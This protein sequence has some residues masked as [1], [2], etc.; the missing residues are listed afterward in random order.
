MVVTEAKTA[1]FARLYEELGNKGGEKKLRQFAKV[2]ENDAIV[3]RFTIKHTPQQNGVAERMN[4]TLLEKVRCKL[5]NAGL[6]KEFWAEAVTYACHLINHLLSAAVDG[7]TPFEKWYGKPVVDYDSL[8]VFGST[9]YYHV[10]ESKLDPRAK[11]AIFI[12]ITSGVKG[13]LLW[14]PMTK[15]NYV[16]FGS[17]VGFGTSS[18]G[19]LEEEIYM[20]QPEGFKVA[21][22]E[23]MEY[24]KRVLQR[25]GIDEKTKPVST[26]LAPQ[27]NLSTTMSPKDEAEREYVSNLPYANVVGN[28]MYSMICTRPDISQAVGVISRYMHN[29]G[30]EHWQAV[31]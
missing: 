10:T 31:K 15:K 26:P 30:K 12:G 14:C 3:R 22:K 24:L 27:F 1:A 25:V 23:N 17:T 5:S 6:G 9:A 13:Y 28:L 4:R 20:T 16:G 2:C 18:D 29:P 21:G 11:K 7:K 8:H 19:N